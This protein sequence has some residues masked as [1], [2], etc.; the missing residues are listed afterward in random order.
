MARWLGFL[1]VVLATAAQWAGALS[2]GYDV[3]RRWPWLLVTG[4][5]GL[6]WLAGY[7]RDWLWVAP[8]ALAG[9]ALAAAAGLLQAFGPGWMVL[10]LVAA[11]CA[12]DLHYW[13]HTRRHLESAEDHR[14]LERAHI[15]RLLAVAG[16][17]L[18][19]AAVALTVE[20]RLTFFLALLLGLLAAWGLG[21]ALGFLRR[22]SE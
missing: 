19:L 2:A 20:L 6:L 16:L 3:A 22:E 21:R 11:L 5:L 7:W 15:R 14:A 12:W 17:A 9:L 10:S 13:V 1:F 18:A 8:L 4:G